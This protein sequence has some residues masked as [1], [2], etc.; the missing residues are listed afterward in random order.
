MDLS[1]IILNYKTLGLVKNCLKAIKDLQLPFDYEIIIVDNNSLDNSVEYLK[2]NYFD[3]KVITSN[4]NLGFAGGINLGINVATGKYLLVLNPDI[5]ILSKA[6]E[7]MFNFMEL[8]P[9][10]GICGPKLLNPDGSLQY[11]CS[12]FPDWR[13]PFYRR[14]FLAKTKRGKNWVNDYLMNDWDHK[15]NRKVEWL[16]GACLMVRR[17]LLKEVGLLDDRYFMYMEDLDWCR[18]FQEKGY[19][20]WYVSEAEVIHYHQRDSAVTAGLK[21]IFKKS[22]RIHLK[23]WLKYYLKYKGKPLP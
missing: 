19:E 11:S 22:G 7:N 20:V 10:A 9:K 12:R 1:I 15:E 16:Y 21:G 3:V 13:L 14:T 2:D 23:S 8:N 6:V 5:L 17:E 18:R 4:V